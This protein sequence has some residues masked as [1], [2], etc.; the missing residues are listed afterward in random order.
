MQEQIHDE[1]VVEVMDQYQAMFHGIKAQVGT[2]LKNID[3]TLA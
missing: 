1:L 3:L 2:V